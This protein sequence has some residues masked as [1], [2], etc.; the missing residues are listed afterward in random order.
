MICLIR[1][2]DRWEQNTSLLVAPEDKDRRT[3]LV[4]DCTIAFLLYQPWTL[5]TVSQ[6]FSTSGTRWLRVT[7]TTWRMRDSHTSTSRPWPSRSSP[8]TSVSH[9]RTALLWRPAPPPSPASPSS[10]WQP[11]YCAAISSDTSL[12]MTGPIRPSINVGPTTCIK[13]IKCS[14]WIILLPHSNGPYTLI[15]QLSEVSQ[16]FCNGLAW[17]WFVTS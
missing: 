15:L 1:C 9:R 10:R 16:S 7:S 17:T 4:R 3:F 6:L 8:S 12:V 5:W 14:P 11:V 13:P 2:S